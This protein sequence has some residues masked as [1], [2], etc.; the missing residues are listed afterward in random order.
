VSERTVR[1]A[2]GRETAVET[3]RTGTEVSVRVGP[4]PDR[5]ILRIKEPARPTEVS[6]EVGGI[7]EPLREVATVDQPDRAE[8]GWSYDAVRAYVWVQL[9]ASEHAVTVRYAVSD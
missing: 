1:P 6:V 8:V 9:A 5:L 2:A 3:R 4:S 7:A